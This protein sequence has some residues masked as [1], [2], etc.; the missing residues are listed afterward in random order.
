MKLAGRFHFVHSCPG[1]TAEDIR[2]MLDDTP[3]ESIALATFRAAIGPE[4]WREIQSNLGYSR[5]TPISKDWHIA[6]FKGTYRGTPAYW[7]TWSAMEYIFTLDGK[8]GPS[9]AEDET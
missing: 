2:S 4:Q 7:L 6:F 3:V 9:L 5:Y 8:M 1:S